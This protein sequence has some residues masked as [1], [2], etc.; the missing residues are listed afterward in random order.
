M[1]PQ[2]FKMK[3]NLMM[4]HLFQLIFLSI[5]F[6]HSL[7]AQIMHY[8]PNS[9]SPTQAD[10]HAARSNA[11]HFRNL[12]SQAGIVNNM[13]K[14][15]EYGQKATQAEMDADR[16]EMR[17]R[18]NEERLRIENE[19]LRREN[20]QQQMDM[21]MEL[22]RRQAEEDSARLQAEADSWAR[23]YSEIER[24]KEQAIRRQD[25]V[26]CEGSPID[27]VFS[28]L[29]KDYVEL[30]YDNDDKTLMHITY[31]Y[32]QK[33]YTSKFLFG[34]TLDAKTGVSHDGLTKPNTYYW[35]EDFV[36][37]HFAY[38]RSGWLVY[39]VDGSPGRMLYAVKQN[40]SRPTHPEIHDP[41]HPDEVVVLN[42][43]SK[44]KIIGSPSLP[45]KS[46]VASMGMTDDQFRAAITERSKRIA[47]LR[48][49]M[50][51]MT[52]TSLLKGN[53]DLRW[54]KDT[55]RLE[56]YDKMSGEVVDAGQV[57]KRRYTDVNLRYAN[58]AYANAP[59]RLRQAQKLKKLMDSAGDNIT[60]AQMEALIKWLDKWQDEADAA[61][62]RRDDAERV[63]NA[64]RMS[65]LRREYG[66]VGAAF[67]DDEV[68]SMHERIQKER[69]KR[70]LEDMAAAP[71]QGDEAGRV[72]RKNRH[73]DN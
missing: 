9:A 44:S 8:N 66:M 68:M 20:I 47:K 12:S 40:S 10:I 45:P 7:I 43:L 56:V 65:E 71:G 28:L 29:G 64:I 5:L 60:D 51:R 48:E 49:R 42:S 30:L 34:Y 13:Y 26:I 15:Q 19:R 33:E 67:S 39:Q 14:M 21:D 59:Q 16:M 62:Q 50:A 53:E 55:G 54:N 46:A 27:R 61:R 23:W 4:R 69:R 6:S 72:G 32:R 2:S 63:R 37:L 35:K 22:Q 17:I 70:I 24:K 25:G 31:I 1:V 41:R 18:G 11:A 58:E 57:A 52:D 36:K 73:A 3:G 38:G